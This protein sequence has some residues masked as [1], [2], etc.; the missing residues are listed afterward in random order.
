MSS[1]STTLSSESGVLSTRLSSSLS[2]AWTT[3]TASPMGTLVKS[4]GT[5]KLTGSELEHRSDVEVLTNSPDPLTNASY[6]RE[7]ESWSQFTLAHHWWQTHYTAVGG[8]TS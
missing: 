6:I 4:E 1:N 3:S 2:L 8:V 7:V 5:S